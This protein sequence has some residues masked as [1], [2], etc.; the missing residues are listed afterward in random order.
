MNINMLILT[1]FYYVGFV[2]CLEMGYFLLK[3]A[4]GNEKLIIFDVL[5]EE[6]SRTPRIQGKMTCLTL[7]FFGFPNNRY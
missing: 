3:M 7:F 5:T 4:K 2:I 1:Y 6:D